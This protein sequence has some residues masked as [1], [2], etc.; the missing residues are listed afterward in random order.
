MEYMSNRG[1]QDQQEC[2][3]PCYLRADGPVEPYHRCLGDWSAAEAQEE[4]SRKFPLYFAA[5][6]C[7][8][9]HG[10]SL[11]H[12]LI[13]FKTELCA[14][15]LVGVYFFFIMHQTP[16]TLQNIQK[17]DWCELCKTLETVSTVWLDCLYNKSP[18][19]G[20]LYTYDLLSYF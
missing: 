7:T 16:L 11:C 14:C 20:C 8:S 19:T 6:D 2:Y 13:Y 10:L 17:Q 4:I 9:H 12:A 1:Q 18:P 5:L 15:M 3:C